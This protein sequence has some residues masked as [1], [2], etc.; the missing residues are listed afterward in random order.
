MQC[1]FTSRLMIRQK[2]TESAAHAWCHFVWSFYSEVRQ[3][4]LHGVI[5]CGHYTRCFTPMCDRKRCVVS[6]CVVILL[7]VLL[8][9]ATESAA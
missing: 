2:A 8:R 6:F 9:C 7:V 3:K 1:Y 5:L 4:A